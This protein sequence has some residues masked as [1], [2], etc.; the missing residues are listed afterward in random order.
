MSLLVFTILMGLPTVGALAAW[1]AAVRSLR[2]APAR[3]D[4]GSSLREARG[5]TSLLFVLPTTLIVFGLVGS[6]L[7]LGR[8]V[9]DAVAHPAALAYGVP[10]FLAGLGMAIVY[11]R[12]TSVAVAAKPDF[13]RVLLLAVMPETS[14]L[15]GLV[16]FFLLIGRGSNWTGFVPFGT[17][18]VWLVS[19]LAM[20]GG[21]GG[22]LGARLAASAWDF[23]TRE[24]WPRALTRSAR[25]GYV[26]VVSFALV[27]VLLQGW[28]ILLVGLLY[29]GGALALGVV[30]F[31]R[32]KHKRLRGMRIS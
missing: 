7:E 20:V 15:F 5:R 17:E 23:A 13:A 11:R 31:L 28:L 30:L 8:A 2:T 14:A 4:P 10:G 21:I 18:A 9:P 16:V 1:F 24:T 22:P 12:G 19:A 32:A 25:G 26:T 29:F 3:V 6:F 27:L